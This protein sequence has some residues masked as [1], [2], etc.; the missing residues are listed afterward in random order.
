MK[1]SVKKALKS[2]IPYILII[3][4]GTLSIILLIWNAERIDKQQ[5]KQ[6]YYIK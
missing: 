4:I 6:T 5:E 3:I 2:V 1:K